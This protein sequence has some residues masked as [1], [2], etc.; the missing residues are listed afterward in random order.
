MKKTFILLCLLPYVLFSQKVENDPYSRYGLGELSDQEISGY[1]SMGHM[2]IANVDRFHINLNNPA[3]V[4]LLGTAAYEVGANAKNATYKEGSKSAKNWGGSFDYIALGFPLKNPI[5]EAYTTER[6]KYRLG[7]AL[8]LNRYSR[9]AYNISSLDSIEG[10]GNF[11]RSY[12]G[13]GGTYKFHWS[14]GIS[15]KNLAVGIDLSYLFGN[16]TSSKDII[17]KDL[18]NAFNNFYNKYYHMNAFGLNLGAIYHLQ[19]N[20][21]Q[22]KDNPSIPLRS[23]R[24]GLTLSP[25]FGFSSQKDELIITRQLIGTTTILADTITDV[26]D[27]AGKGKLPLE[28]GGG[29]MYQAGEKSCVG[30]EFKYGGWSKYYNEATGEKAG[31]LNNSFQIAM[32]GYVRP[33][34]K[35]Y[36][37]FWKRAFYKYGAYYR[38]DP[39]VV[40]DKQV[41]QYGV[42]FGTGLPFV[43]QRKVA[44]ADIGV[45]IGKK[46]S[47]TIIEENYI[48]INFGFTFNDDEWFIKRKYN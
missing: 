28:I 42:T 23:L 13:N 37:S 41:D 34:Y 16:I 29:V 10:I 24:F 8:G 3:S 47:G 26:Y 48:K 35:S 46:G 31:S 15:Y 27:Q 45:D 25:G 36:T 11:E 2:S 38:Q 30:I 4:A 1:R 44:H 32:G 20:A 7:M 5:N 19:L 21:K 14:N 22:A 18:E 40:A 39:R 6:S 33:S 9:T 17:F 43:F 12:S